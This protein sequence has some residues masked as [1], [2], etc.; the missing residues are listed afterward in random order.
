LKTSDV[1]EALATDQIYS[2][3]GMCQALLDSRSHW[4]PIATLPGSAIHY[5]I[6]RTGEGKSRETYAAIEPHRHVVLQPQP[7][8]LRGVA[9]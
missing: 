9:A 8:I 1:V 4:L 5:G 3:I 7:E 6:E 2:G